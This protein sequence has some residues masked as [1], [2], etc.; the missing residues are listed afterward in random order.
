MVFRENV[1]LL[2]QPGKDRAMYSQ[3]ELRKLH[4][5]SFLNW[6]SVEKSSFCGCFYCLSM[7][8]AEEAVKLEEGEGNACALCPRCGVDSVLGDVEVALTSEL[9]H[10]LHS[11]AF[12]VKKTEPFERED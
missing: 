3:Q 7:F 11:F 5:K 10:E 9:L 4:R 1:R 12:R 6:A 2:I 8:P